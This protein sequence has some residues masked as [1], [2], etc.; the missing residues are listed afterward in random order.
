MSVNGGIIREIPL[1][2]EVAARYMRHIEAGRLAVFGAARLAEAAENPASDRAVDA[3]AWRIESLCTDDRAQAFMGVGR[4]I[5]RGADASLEL[6][7]NPAGTMGGFSPDIGWDDAI[8]SISGLRTE[9]YRKTPDG[10]LLPRRYTAQEGLY[11]DRNTGRAMVN[12]AVWLTRSRRGQSAT[13]AASATDVGDAYRALEVSS[14]Q[15]KLVYA[16]ALRLPLYVEI[17]SGL[18]P[19]AI[20]GQ[21]AYTSKACIEVDKAVGNY[22]NR[23]GNYPSAVLAQA[24]HFAGQVHAERASE[25]ILFMVGDGRHLPLPDKSVHE[26]FMSNVLNADIGDEA[27]HGMLA[28][29]ARVAEQYGSMVVRANWHTDVWPHDKMLSL[30]RQYFSVPR[31]VEADDV[32]YGRLETQYGKPSEVAAPDG[33]YIIGQP[34]A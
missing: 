23:F 4:R 20:R 18:D 16:Q 6:S 8:A 33:Y 32:S 12:K 31:S 29:A 9:T 25:H 7:W 15:E 27:R 21:R 11:I 17:G 13:N 34:R 3:L 19:M 14:A 22:D 26:V 28:E 24:S 10:R 5:V 1:E 30:V 2:P